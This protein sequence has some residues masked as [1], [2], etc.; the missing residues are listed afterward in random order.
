MNYSTC[1]VRILNPI[2]TTI[3][4]NN[5]MCPQTI[6]PLI[7]INHINISPTRLKP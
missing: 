6:H 2:F 5:H 1:N 7:I 3:Q 4:H